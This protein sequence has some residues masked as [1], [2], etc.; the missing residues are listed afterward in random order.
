MQNT[1]S[2]KWAIR[3]TTKPSVNTGCMEDMATVWE[4]SQNCSLGSE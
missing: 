2:A 1:S 4:Q 3:M